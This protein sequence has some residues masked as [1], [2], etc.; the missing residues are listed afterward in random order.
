MTDRIPAVP[1]PYEHPS[2]WRAADM[3]VPQRYVI[4]LD[5]SDVAEIDLSLIHI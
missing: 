3:A 4:T 5:A 1:Q 2:A